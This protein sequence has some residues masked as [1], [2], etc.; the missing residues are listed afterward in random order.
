[1]GEEK[2]LHPGP[3]RPGEAPG[4]SVDCKGQRV[5]GW[6][7]GP[8]PVATMAYLVQSEEEEEEEGEGEA[9][10]G[11]G[12]QEAVLD[13]GVH[14]G[15]HP[16]SLS[17]EAGKGAWRGLLLQQRSAVPGPGHLGRQGLGGPH[18]SRT[19][20]PGK[21]ASLIPGCRRTWAA[22]S[23]ATAMERPA[24]G[25]SCP[26][27]A[28]PGCAA[29]AAEVVSKAGL[30]AAL[31]PWLSG[32]S[33]SDSSRGSSGDFGRWRAKAAPRGASAGA[34]RKARRGGGGDSGDDGS[35]RCVRSVARSAA[36]ARGPQCARR[37]P[38]PAAPPPVW[39]PARGPRGG[40]SLLA[41]PRS[42]PGLASA[43]RVDLPASYRR[44]GISVSPTFPFSPFLPL[45]LL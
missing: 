4:Y 28:F 37:P 21:A 2:G 13:C 45:R 1:M 12:V 15:A 31:A 39:G 6:G 18:G 11:K 41:A 17:A 30:D 10:G 24:P 33:G 14:A 23:A 43:P 7:A 40:A 8:P 36:E 9:G 20:R 29:A 32:S 44:V 16:G 34:G 42:T 5:T 26:S 19:G 38:A 27:L 35:G 22:G 3:A 25:P